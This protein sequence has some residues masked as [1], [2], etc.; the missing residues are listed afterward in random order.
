MDGNKGRDTFRHEDNSPVGA[1]RAPRYPT[2]T[3]VRVHLIGATLGY[4]RELQEEQSQRST[5]TEPQVLEE[6]GVGSEIILDLVL[7]S[8][9]LEL[10]LPTRDIVRK[11]FV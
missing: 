9:P 6:I 7:P 1:P 4:N 11:S 2:P 5:N 10:D 8:V 3:S